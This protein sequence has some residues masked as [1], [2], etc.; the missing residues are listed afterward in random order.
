M[1]INVS[2]HAKL[3]YV[4]RIIGI[5]EENEAKQYL[6]MHENMVVEKILKM[7][8]FATFVY[9]GQI[10]PDKS[11]PTAKFFLRD[12]TVIITDTGNSKIITLYKVNFGLPERTTRVVIKDLMEDLKSLQEQLESAKVESYMASDSAKFQIDSYTTSIAN[13]EQQLKLMK[14]LK[15]A[16]EAEL[17]NLNHRPMILT[18][19]VEECASKICNSLELKRD[20]EQKIF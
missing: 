7:F 8:E 13:L 4:Q 17:L 9:Q 20:I 2:A 10:G 1:A 11:R 3:R 19:Q 14:E 15:S 6:A 12:D 18:K 5:K 16:A